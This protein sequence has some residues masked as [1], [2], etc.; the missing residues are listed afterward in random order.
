[1]NNEPKNLLTTRLD[2]RVINYQGDDDQICDAARVSFD[3]DAL[4]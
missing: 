2:V 1:M 3:K 4:E